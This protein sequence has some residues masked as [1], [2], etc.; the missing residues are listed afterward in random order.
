MAMSTL[1][2]SLQSLPGTAN[3]SNPTTNQE[4]TTNHAL[5]R[6][7]LLKNLVRDAHSEKAEIVS[8]VNNSGGNVNLQCNSGF[9]L[10]VVRPAFS[11]F[12]AGFSNH[13]LGI[14]ISMPNPPTTTKDSTDLN[15]TVLYQFDI[16]AASQA[17]KRASIHLH[18]TS[19]LIQIQGGSRL[20]DL[21]TIAVWL[22]S[23]VVL[24]LLSEYATT[25]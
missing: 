11:F 9:F 12:R 23:N 25:A 18:L 10:S 16:A 8:E 6:D 17:S 7:T 22:T 4:R 13:V 2:D 24:P 3:H 14:K 19:R 5:N 21:S 1:A 20:T 15:E